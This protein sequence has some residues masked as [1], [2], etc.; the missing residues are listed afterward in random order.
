LELLLRQFKIMDCTLEESPKRPKGIWVVAQKTDSQEEWG[1]LPSLR[2]VKDK[3]RIS[4]K[5]KKR[6]LR[7]VSGT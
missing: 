6:F 2:L 3:H 5:L 7:L 4:E 1:Q